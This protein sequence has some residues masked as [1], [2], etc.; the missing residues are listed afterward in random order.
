MNWVDGCAH[1][2]DELVDADAPPRAEARAVPEACDVSPLN[3]HVVAAATP[4]RRR[5]V[6]ATRAA[7]HQRNIHVAAAA[8]PRL[9][10]TEYPRR[11]R[12]A[13]ATRP[14]N[15]RAAKVRDMS[16]GPDS[17]VAEIL[18]KLHSAHNETTS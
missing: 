15:I 17:N 4:R 12:G 11:S 14:R 3:I 13:A 2:H 10:S 7:I 1:F 9:V 16:N 6:A 5:G 8:S 18:K